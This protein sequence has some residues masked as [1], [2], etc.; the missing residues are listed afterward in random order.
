MRLTRRTIVIATLTAVL[1]GQA[2]LAAAQSSET[3]AKPAKLFTTND[4]LSVTLSA[5]WRQITVKKT[6]QGTY[7]ATIEY[8]DELGN[9]AK[10]PL[11]VQ[12]RGITRQRVCRYPPIKLQFEKANVKGTTFRGQKSLKM[13]TH[14]DKASRYE[15]YYILEMLAYRMYNLINDM[16]FRVR[17][18]QITYVDSDSGHSDEPRFAFLIEDDSDVADRF[19]LKKLRIPKLGLS[20]MD[21]K[22]SS[23]FSLFQYMIGNVDWAALKGPDPKECCHNV[24]L[25]G[26]RPFED[27]D[28][29]YPLPYDFD[30]SG[31][32]DADYAAPP[33][34]L[35]IK[36]VTQ[37]LFRGYCAH[38]ETME[39]ARLLF[40]EREQAIYGLVDS[41]TRLSEKSRKQTNRYLEKFFKTIRDE[42]DFEKEIIRQCR[43]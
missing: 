7:P 11:T 15:E 1:A 16:S 2:P 12:R 34:G 5:P 21:A 36:Y 8:T 18:L 14:C 26:P 43:R 17:P 19:E 35:P 23:E 32:V 9:P 37:R 27:G 33:A 25:I 41:E 38:N 39:D 20:Q 13:V 24:K 28:I 22:T 30:S 40:L 3:A 31:L 10:L 42:R 29:A 4:T 6:Y